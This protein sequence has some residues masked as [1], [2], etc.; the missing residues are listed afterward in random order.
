MCK[1]HG[2]VSEIRYLAGLSYDMNKTLG[3][4][5]SLYLM[6][7]EVQLVVLGL[8]WRGKFCFKDLI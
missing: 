4:N 7:K 8:I 1:A 6:Y 2:G 3:K 5:K